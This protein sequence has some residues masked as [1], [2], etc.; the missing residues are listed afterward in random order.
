MVANN[1]KDYSDG[2]GI[3]EDD[4]DDDKAWRFIISFF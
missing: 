3:D 2:V 4:D 1:G